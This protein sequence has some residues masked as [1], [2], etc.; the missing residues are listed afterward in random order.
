VTVSGRPTIGKIGIGFIAANEL[1]E[2]MEIFTTKQGSTTVLHVVVDF[3]AMRE[4][5]AERKL[6]DSSVKK[7]DYYGERLDAPK[8]DHYTRIFLRALRGGARELFNATKR[9][10]GVEGEGAS[11]YGLRPESIRTRLRA[12]PRSWAEFDFYSQTM[13]GLA[14]NVPIRYASGWV[15]GPHRAKVRDLEDHVRDLG[16]RVNYDGTELYKPTV[17]EPGD[18]RNVL[19]TFHIQGEKVSARGYLYAKHGTLFPTELNG[20]LIRIRNAAVGGYDPTFLD[21]P[22]SMYTLFQRWVSG[23]LWADDRLEEAMNIDRATL[24]PIDPAFAELQTLFHQELERFLHSVRIRLYTEPTAEKRKLTARREAQQIATT[25]KRAPTQLSP[26][27]KAS[28]EREW[29]RD[30]DDPSA[31]RAVLRK[32]SVAEIYELVVDIAQD[33]LSPR[34]AQRFL[35]EMTR[36]LRRR[37]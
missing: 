22:N 6:N 7:G 5:S 2:E 28:V 9:A 4:P 19:T 34:D 24:R 16:F 31:I 37:Q 17:L 26:A 11:L 36:R 8:G 20:V 29:L 25:V 12:A 33:I 27:A 30:P 18:A 14:L 1:C 21:Y 15:P 32:Y 35:L 10:R 13:L 3:S 23:E